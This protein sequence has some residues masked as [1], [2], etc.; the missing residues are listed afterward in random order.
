MRAAAENSVKSNSY[1]SW[2]KSKEDSS[3]TSD[4]DAGKN[5]LSCQL[6]MCVFLLLPV[7][8]LSSE[9]SLEC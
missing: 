6:C 3:I 1:F 4:A 2:G 7:A 8:D 5:I 9:P